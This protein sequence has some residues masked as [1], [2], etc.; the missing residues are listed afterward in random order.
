LHLPFLPV[1][2]CLSSRF[3]H[4]ADDKQKDV[5]DEDEDEDDNKENI[6]GSDSKPAAST[7]KGRVVTMVTTTVESN[8]ESMGFHRKQ[9]WMPNYALAMWKDDNLR[10]RVTVCI[11]FDA[12]VNL[13][14][15]VSYM[16][17]DDG[18]S[19]EIKCKGIQRLGDVD[20]LHEYHRQQDK[21]SLP[22]FHPKIIAFKEFFQ[23]LKLF[24]AETTYNEAT[25]SL[26]FPVQASFLEDL[27]LED[28]YKSLTVYLEMIAVEENNWSSKKKPKLVSMKA[29]STA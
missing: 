7:K 2:S 25:I 27:R 19:L 11:A 14:D 10:K 6:L 13:N 24:E 15:D 12:G 16:V 26:P 4:A 23:V 1:P 9:A 3:A 5:D 8:N 29:D 17:S 21:H 22:K 18:L 20:T 28:Q